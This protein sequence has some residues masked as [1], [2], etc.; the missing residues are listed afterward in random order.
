[1]GGGG[2]MLPSP[3][4]APE[5]ALSC[6][7][8]GGSGGGGGMLAIVKTGDVLPSGGSAGG[9]ATAIACA[10]LGVELPGGED[11]GRPGGALSGAA[12]SG[13]GGNCGGVFSMDFPGLGGA[14]SGA[15]LGGGSNVLEMLC[16]GLI[17]PGGAVVGAP[18]GTRFDGALASNAPGANSSAPGRCCGSEAG[19]G[20][21][22]MGLPKVGGIPGCALVGGEVGGVGMFMLGVLGLACVLSGEPSRGSLGVWGVALA[23]PGGNPGGNPFSQCGGGTYAISSAALVATQSNA[24]FGDGGGGVLGMSPA[25]R[26]TAAPVGD[27]MPMEGFAPTAALLRGMLSIGISV[28]E[29]AAG[30]MWLP[31]VPSGATGGN[32][33]A[34]GVAETAAALDCGVTATAPGLGAVGFGLVKADCTLLGTISACGDWVIMLLSGFGWMPSGTPSVD[35]SG[36]CDALHTAATLTSLFACIDAFFAPD[37]AVLGSTPSGRAS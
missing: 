16:V 22:G 35:N 3:G 15:W 4:A 25:R 19:T 29:A 18:S 11:G 30:L 20:V 2:G 17:R 36:G 14:G 12:C 8:L 37:F 13:G 5:A 21:F 32:D 23:S 28:T 34:E 26:A 27:A 9:V 1:M 7:A 6:I 10:R 31:V 24:T 33:E